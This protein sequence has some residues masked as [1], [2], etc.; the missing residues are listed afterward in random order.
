MYTVSLEACDDIAEPPPAMED[1]IDAGRL[2]ARVADVLSDL[3]ASERELIRKHY[4]DGKDLS[5]A[6]AELGISRSWSSRLHARA[7]D[8]IRDRLADLQ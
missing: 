5:E 8:R 7:I 6:G 2:S 1:R 4:W 3:P